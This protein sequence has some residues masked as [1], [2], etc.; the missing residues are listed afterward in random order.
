MFRA[1][2]AASLTL[3][4]LLAVTA[5]GDS[6]PDTAD[7]P[8]P[9]SMGA[10]FQGQEM[11]PEMMALM[12]EAQQLQEELAPIQ[13]EAMADEALSRQLDEVRERVETAMREQDPE[14]LDRM[15]ALE[16]EF[17]AA[18]AQGDEARAQAIGVEAQEIQ[19]QLQVAQE[20]V[21]SRPD[22]QEPIEAFEEAHRARMRE[23]D[24]R[25]EEIM[26]RLEEIFRELGMG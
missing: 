26:D 19:A 17:M 14:L 16:G 4:L 6:A 15:E 1:R 5:C 3:A 22:I 21:L 8:P 12:M 13:E 10:P 7:G 24:P 23:I 20:E 2:T 9:E 25:A 18:Q 11:D